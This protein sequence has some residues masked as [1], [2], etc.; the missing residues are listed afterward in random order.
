MDPGN[1]AEQSFHISETFV[2][3]GIKEDEPIPDDYI[4]AGKK[5]A[6]KQLVIGGNRLANLLMSLDLEYVDETADR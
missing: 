5:L 4:A 2:Y 1:W 3:D 6:E